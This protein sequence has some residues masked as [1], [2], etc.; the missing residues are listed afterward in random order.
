MTA[1]IFKVCYVIGLIVGSVIRGVYA[2]LRSSNCLRLFANTKK[3]Y[4]ITRLIKL[5]RR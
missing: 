5:R 2:M 1:T 4:A 3:L